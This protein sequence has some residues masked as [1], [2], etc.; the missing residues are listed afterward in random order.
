[1]K[2]Q[3]VIA[4]AVATLGLAGLAGGAAF[5]TSQSSNGT[6]PMSSLVNA[7]ATKF[8]LKTAD[9]QAV[10]DANKTQ[11]Q[12]QR[13]Q[14]V[15]DQVA[16]LVK[17][18][19]LTQA[20]ADKINAKR[21]ELEKAREAERTADQNLTETQRQAKREQMRTQM[22]AKKTELDAWLKSN[23]ID[24]QYGYLLMG[25]GRGHGP[26]GPDGDGGPRDTKRAS[27]SS[28]SSTSSSTN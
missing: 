15:K 21:T 4:S 24:T 11:M 16:Q 20:Q 23:S 18:G 2:K 25:G 10:F 3:L 8:N 13:E 22:D 1:M 12:A 14:Q 26:G 17:D 19:K 28:T 7:I 6:D 9:V 27:S 5:A